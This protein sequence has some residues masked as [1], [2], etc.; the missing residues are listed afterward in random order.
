MSS[1]TPETLCALYGKA[2]NHKEHRG[3]QRE[4]IDAGLEAERH[5]QFNLSIGRGA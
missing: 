2:F 1:S 4:P 5:L 3:P